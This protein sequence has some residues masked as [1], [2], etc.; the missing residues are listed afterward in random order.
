M[1]VDKEATKYIGLTIKWDYKSRK[2]H[3]HMPE[4]FQKALT[5]FNH[6]TPTEIQNSPHLHVIPQYGAKMQ[7]VKDNNLSQPL[8]KEETKYAQAVAGTLLHYA[9]AVDTTILTALSLIATKQAKPMQETMK[10]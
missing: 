1:I 2:A 6:K 8:S 9:R 4:Y 10:K 7:Y 5:R 3:I